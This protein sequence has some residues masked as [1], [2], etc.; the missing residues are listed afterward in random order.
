MIIQCM[1]H[2]INLITE[3]A[4]KHEWAISLLKTCQSIVTYC[5]SDHRP[6]ALLAKCHSDGEPKLSGYVTRW[7]SAGQCIQSVPLNEQALH[8]LVHDHK[9]ELSAVII[10]TITNR[11]YSADCQHIINM[12]HTLMSVIGSHETHTTTLADCYQ[13]SESGCC[14]E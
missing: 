9:A 8:R 10:T 11:Q 4:M 1:P 5:G 14:N 12:L 6:N 13:Q 7:Y 2:F 3:D